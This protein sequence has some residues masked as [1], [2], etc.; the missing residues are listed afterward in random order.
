MTRRAAADSPS[1]A[2]RRRKKGPATTTKAP[3]G[4]GLWPLAISVAAGLFLAGAALAAHWPAAHGAFV[5]D[6]T[7]A[8][9][10]NPLV[11]QVAGLPR[12]WFSTQQPDYWPVA[13]TTHWIEWRIW[14]ADPF[15][16]RVVNLLIHGGVAVLVWRL[17]RWAQVPGAW[18]V[19]LAMAVHP[20]SSE[21]VNWVIQRK[22]LLATGLGIGGLLA[23]LD[24]HERS[25][26][27][28][29]WAAVGLFALAMLSKT[30][31]VMLPVCLLLLLW[32]KHRRLSW[33]DLRFAAPW[34]AVALVLG[35]IGL[36]F[37]ERFAIGE[38]IV[39]TDGIAGRLAAA[40]WAVWFYL[41]KALLP[42]NLSFV[43]PRW[44]IDATSPL[45]YLPLAAL[46]AVMAVLYRF[47]R[48]WS[49][50]PGTALA[51]YL[52]N[53][54][55]VLGLANIYFMK[56]SLVADHWQYLAL[57]GVLAL[58][59]GVCT[60]QLDRLA[61][62]PWPA[63]VA[64]VS[65]CAVLLILTRERATF[66]GTGDHE[67]LW[68]DTIAR[69]P[70]GFLAHRNLGTLLAARGDWGA[71]LG[72][73][74]RAVE[75]APKEAENHANLGRVFEALGEHQRAEVEFGH[76]LEQHPNDPRYLYDL[77]HSLRQEG[78]LDEAFVL[79]QRAIRSRPDYAQA[80]EGLGFV[81]YKRHQLVEASQA[82]R[83]AV[84]LDP[85]LGSAHQDLGV[86]LMAQGRIDEAVSELRRA[87][88]CSPREPSA[89]LALGEALYSKPDLD[90]AI[91]AYRDGVRLAPGSAAGRWL[92]GR[93]LAD[94]GKWSEAA[95][96]M[97]KV[98]S[99]NPEHVQ[100]RVKLAEI[101]RRPAAP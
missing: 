89:R 69:N 13:Y 97:R 8:I 58:V 23:A 15:G 40:G 56:Y 91:L 43:Y 94:A 55:P 26:R 77:A 88:D 93:S 18:L 80:L 64:T 19:G 41:G 100:A 72:H 31:V 3:A 49:A 71:A 16:Y 98:L 21:T 60:A 42:V 7:S 84:Q 50:A 66:Y 45:S 48:T 28:L 75:L 32:W 11:T 99:I 83:A 5:W 25:Q 79:Y 30:S 44:E 9:I 54:L 10:E 29:Y 82:L 6:D 34:F 92:L 47:R 59:I 78:R 86:V 22:T 74:Q 65:L 14:G 38:E 68:H 12:I 33:L 39:R 46:L 17:A 101:E 73:S 37:Q 76:A 81:L 63:R 36:I 87:V 62:S 24:A 1:S 85:R 96:E 95:V 57:P 27:A 52:L 53:L 20:L 61:A 67:V 70:S 2:A 4:S 35:T 51:W 90:G